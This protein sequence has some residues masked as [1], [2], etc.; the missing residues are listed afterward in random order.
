MKNLIYYPGFEVKDVDWL[1]FALLYVDALNPIIP[2]SGDKY[3]SDLH[4]KLQSETDFIVTHRPNNFEG[5]R[6]TLDAI[7][8][9]E[10]VLKDPHSYSQIFDRPDFL[11]SWKL[12]ANHQYEL[13][14]E[15]YTDAW[16]AFCVEN[17]LGTPTDEGIKVHM[18]LGFVFMS[19]LA[20]TIAESR[21]VSPI[22]DY[23][24]LDKFSIFTR[25]KTNMAEMK[26]AQ[27]VIELELPTSLH[28]IELNAIIALR[29]RSGFKERLAAFHQELSDY[30][31]SVETGAPGKFVTSFNSAWQ[32]LSPHILTAGLGTLS[33]GLGIW[34]AIDAASD[35]TFL[36]EVVGGTMVAISGAVNISKTWKNTETRRFT[37]KYLADLTKI[38]AANL[39][40]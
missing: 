14:E 16:E 34:I 35:A 24:N 17:S 13:F 15:K 29:N 38:K 40:D 26:V 3:L 37:R 10:K 36:K 25:T 2:K 23:S 39:S 27:A 1:K 30:L 5:L 20:Q 11:D 7:E 28:D 9:V 22:T 32:E 19:L 21:S 12:P 6:A 18:E 4:K 33:V 8:E 31:D